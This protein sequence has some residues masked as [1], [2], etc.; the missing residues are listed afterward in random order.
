[1]FFKYYQDSR[2]PIQ[3]R[4]NQLNLDKYQSGIYISG[5]LNKP[6]DEIYI[7]SLQLKGIKSLPLKLVAR[8]PKNP[9]KILFCFHGLV[10]DLNFSFY[11][12]E[13]SCGKDFALFFPQ[14]PFRT[15]WL[16]GINGP[17]SWLYFLMIKYF[18]EYL[19]NV[20]ELEKSIFMGTSMGAYGALLNS[21]FCG[22]DETYVSS[23]ITSLNPLLE[24]NNTLEVKGALKSL[25][26]NLDFESLLVK[27]PGLDIQNLLKDQ[28][29][30]IN[31]A[32]RTLDIKPGKSY[33]IINFR[34]E[35]DTDNQGIGLRDF[36]LPFVHQL[37]SSKV[38][39]SMFV[40]PCSGHDALFYPTH[41]ARFSDEVFSQCLSG[42]EP[43]CFTRKDLVKRNLFTN[44]IRLKV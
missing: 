8:V 1:M 28:N 4:I 43:L 9:Q 27:Y 31:F 35:N 44:L 41:V 3:I 12:F 38:N 33:H 34:F 23:P 36:I 39:Y 25:G 14:D 7:I 2:L 11:D 42:S 5:W 19:A 6:Y 10:A 16:G 32:G 26:L 24:F 37:I 20:N 22:P 30:Q 29:R 15:C 21:L 40:I 18:Y 17:E 13:E